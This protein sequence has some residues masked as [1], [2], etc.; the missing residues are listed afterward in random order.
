MTSRFTCYVPK[1]WLSLHE[2]FLKSTIKDEAL[3]QWK[4][5]RYL[6]GTTIRLENVTAKLNYYRFSPWMRKADDPNEYPRVSQYFGI[7]MKCILCNIS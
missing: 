1:E 6:D 5:C 7:E 2:E 3:K 4:H